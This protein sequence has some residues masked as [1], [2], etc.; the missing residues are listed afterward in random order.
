MTEYQAVGDPCTH[1]YAVVCHDIPSSR[2]H[3]HIIVKNVVDRLSNFGLTDFMVCGGYYT[4]G[5]RPHG[6]VLI[7][8]VGLSEA[9]A[10]KIC[11]DVQVE[12]C[13][14]SV[15]IA[16]QTYAMARYESGI[17]QEPESWERLTMINVRS[18][19]RFVEYDDGRF[20]NDAKKG[21][22]KV[23]LDDSRGE[24]KR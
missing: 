17:V 14:D 24:P 20:N 11:T 18:G 8:D 2:D 9:D 7:H 10:R 22:D 12:F 15:P 16:R 1:A 21:Y 23:L 4:H 19:R 6:S 13:V 3:I 5:Q